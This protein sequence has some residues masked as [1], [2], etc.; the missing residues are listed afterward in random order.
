MRKLRSVFVTLSI[1]ILSSC[2]TVVV[3]NQE[4]CG[5]FGE[6]GAECFHTQSDDKRTVPK[7]QWDEERFG[8]LCAKPSVFADVK[9]TILKL[10][11]AYKKCIYDSRTDTVTFWNGEEQEETVVTFFSDIEEFKTEVKRMKEKTL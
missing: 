5:D 2:G 6:A 11:K 7:V 9:A 8:M 4:W 10:C 3:K 1:L